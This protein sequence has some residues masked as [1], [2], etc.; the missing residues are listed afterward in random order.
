MHDILDLIGSVGPL[1]AAIA[2]IIGGLYAVTKNARKFR[3]LFA[4]DQT[5]LIVEL[6]LLAETR[7]E[8]INA[9][10]VQLASEKAARQQAV[11]ERDFARKEA[12]SFERR[13]N[14][15]RDKLFLEYRP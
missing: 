15:L 10:T 7:Q 4:S 1:L 5:P 8:M 11:E 2:A 6:R 13:L 3:A 9:L 14:D 12:D